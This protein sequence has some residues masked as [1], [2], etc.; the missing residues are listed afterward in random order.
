MRDELETTYDVRLWKTEVYKGARGASHRVRWVVAGRPF[1]EVFRTAAAANFRS[2]L[3]TAHTA[4]ARRSTSSGCRSASCGAV[5]PNFAGTSLPLQVRRHEVAGASP[6]H[7]K[8]I[9]ESLIT[10]TPTMIDE[11]MSA[12]T[13]RLS[14]RAAQLGI[15]RPSRQRSSTCEPPNVWTGRPVASD[16]SVTWAGQTARAVLEGA[17]DQARRWPG[18]RQDGGAQRANV[19]NALNYAVE[20]GLLD[21]NPLRSISW[22]PPKSVQVVVT[23]DRWPTPT[24]LGVARSGR[25]T[26]RATTPALCLLRLPL[27]LRFAP[28]GAV[29][30]RRPGSVCRRGRR[31]DHTGRPLRKSIGTGQRR[32]RAASSGS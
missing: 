25:A 20:L 17:G 13:P 27:L 30:I 8:S 15:Y 3:V 22:K 31:M 16:P 14:G 19:S 29:S 1:K 12:M 28:R 18:R 5:R 6:K 23:V 24:R 21:A 26:R 11:A 32:G 10:A 2:K 9:A 7:R 4:R